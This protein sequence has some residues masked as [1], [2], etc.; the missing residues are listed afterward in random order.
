M[1]IEVGVLVHPLASLA[2]TES[3]PPVALGVRL[4]EA[5]VE[6]P[7]H[8]AGAVQVYEVAVATEAAV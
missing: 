4:I 8:P 1:V 2:T 5:V 7:V 6:L 3:V